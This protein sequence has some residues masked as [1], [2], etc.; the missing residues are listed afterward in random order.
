MSFQNFFGVFFVVFVFFFFPQIT[1]A[2]TPVYYSVGQ[3]ADDHQTG[4]STI[5]I[6]SG[7]A[8][9]S[10]AQTASNMGIGDRVT[11]GTASTTA[12]IA[13]KIS[14]TQWMLVTAT[15]T[16]VA[17][18]AVATSVGSIIHEYTSLSAAEA[19]AS[20]ANHIGT[21]SLVYADIQLNIPLYYDSGPDTNL[22][23]V[24][25]WETSSTSY[26]NIYTP[27]DTNTE[28]NQSQRHDGKK[29]GKNGYYMQSTSSAS[30]NNLEVEASYTI[31][32]G[33]KFIRTSSNWSYGS[34]IK[35]SSTVF[36]IDGEFLT[37]KN[38]L[39]YQESGGNDGN[40]FY[41]RYSAN[42]A[43][44]TRFYNNILVSD[45][46]DLRYGI[47]LLPSYATDINRQSFYY[48]NTVYGKYKLAAFRIKQTFTADN[49][50]TPKIYNNYVAN[51]FAT[52]SI[53]DFLFDGTT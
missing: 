26:I 39:L 42:D 25:G 17:D 27:I 16:V 14:T 5:T 31:I 15:G 13:S 47:N 49:D 43:Y 46:N 18:L 21:S 53:P 35:I 4:T 41:N 1:Q 24:S 38:N 51:T 12:Y 37:I 50:Y 44:G 20:D 36:D 40:L 48:N 32:N 52:T 2:A 8:T 29:N 34:A 6:S 19:G 22:T 11:Y 3:N 45:S 23:L 10:T 30:G 9:F 7:L 33:L 28:V